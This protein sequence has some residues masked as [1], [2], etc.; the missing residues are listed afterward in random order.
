MEIQFTLIF[1][2]TLVLA[3][4][5]QS[6]ADAGSS[7]ITTLPLVMPVAYICH[8]CVYEKIGRGNTLAYIASSSV[9]KTKSFTRFEPVLNY[10]KTFL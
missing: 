9:L 2:K 8:I 6:F 3:L 10:H 4:S 1:K 7:N 5:V